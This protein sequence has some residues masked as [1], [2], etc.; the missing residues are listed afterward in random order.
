MPG[1]YSIINA[2]MRKPDCALE[3]QGVRGLRENKRLMTF[4]D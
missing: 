3:F 4:R 2:N 1:R